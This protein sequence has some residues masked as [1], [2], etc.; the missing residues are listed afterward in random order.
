M[1]MHGSAI[2][3][4]F[5]VDL[6]GTEML[7][8]PAACRKPRYVDS[9][10]AWC[11]CGCT[12]ILRLQ[13][14]AGCPSVF[15]AGAQCEV[16]SSSSLY[17]VRVVPQAAPRSV[18]LDRSSAE[19]FFFFFLPLFLLLRRFSLSATLRHTSQDGPRQRT[20]A[21]RHMQERWR[22]AGACEAAGTC[23]AALPVAVRLVPPVAICLLLQ[24]R[25]R[26]PGTRAQTARAGAQVHVRPGGWP[27]AAVAESRRVRSLP[28]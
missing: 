7:R 18:S 20:D 1:S 2:H 4:W 25:R 24:F 6:F 9:L 14:V 3:K 17:R 27:A 11:C 10:R 21:G 28:C 22:C 26:G 15:V 19:I 23:S 5:S 13:A 8:R 16:W 12:F